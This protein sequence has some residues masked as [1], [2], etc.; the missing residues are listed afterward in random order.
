MFYI[1]ML[2]RDSAKRETYS[3]GSH[4]NLINFEKIYENGE[5][6]KVEFQRIKRL[7]AEQYLEDL[8]EKEEQKE[9]KKSVG[10]KI[11]D[12]DSILKKLLAGAEKRD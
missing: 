7:L 9:L 11:Q 10:I 6:S 4:K 12:S 5:L 3:K 2:I 8:Q 1:I